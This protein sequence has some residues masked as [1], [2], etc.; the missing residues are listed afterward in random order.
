[1]LLPRT[2]QTDLFQSDG[3]AHAPKS[4][5]TLEISEET[6]PA[7]IE[8]ASSILEVDLRFQWEEYMITGNFA[9]S[10]PSADPRPAYTLKWL[11]KKLQYTGGTLNIK[12]WVLLRVLL[13]RT[14]LAKVAR[15][16]KEYRFTDS[17][18]KT[19]EALY[20][21]STPKPGCLRQKANFTGSL[22][23]SSLNTVDGS[24]SDSG[25]S[26]KRKRGNTPSDGSVEPV[27]EGG[28]GL[29][30]LYLAVCG[31]IEQ[32]EELCADSENG[33]GFPIEHLRFAT[34]S[35]REEAAAIFGYA[36]YVANHIIR[37]SGKGLSTKVA[38][39]APQ[40]DTADRSCVISVAKFWNG[41]ARGRPGIS[42]D[43]NNV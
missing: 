23:D 38:F 2:D 6:F 20:K 37:D 24:L 25:P 34:R 8:T 13:V 12:A 22:T 11:L 19:L 5:L 29:R 10:I 1:M 16:L 28:S 21:Y 33:R 27:S 41:R 30:M 39:P 9:P 26:K 35:F 17:L 4:I 36:I 15:L 31:V 3:T 14:P 43:M 32:I 40:A 18:R 42:D 7:Q